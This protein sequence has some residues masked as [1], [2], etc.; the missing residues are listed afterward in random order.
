MSA[1]FRSWDSFVD[2]WNER[3]PSDKDPDGKPGDDTAE[4]AWFDARFHAIVTDLVGTPTELLD[5]DGELSWRARTTPVMTW[6]TGCPHWSNVSVAA[7][8]G[9]MSSKEVERVWG[10]LPCHPHSVMSKRSTP[11]STSSLLAPKQADE[12]ASTTRDT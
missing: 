4:Q 10:I 3:R 6:G 8:P 2:L 11:C 12:H 9:L 7:W 1:L 5:P